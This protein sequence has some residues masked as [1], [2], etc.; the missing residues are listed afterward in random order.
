MRVVVVVSGATRG[1]VG[2]A[3]PSC[4]NHLFAMMMREGEEQAATI[5]LRS[6]IT[7]DLGPTTV[8]K[9]SESA[10]LYM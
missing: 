9:L 2:K 5:F 4:T 6:Y 10:Y 3:P 7:Q 1:K 8:V